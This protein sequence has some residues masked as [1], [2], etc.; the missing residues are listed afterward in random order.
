MNALDFKNKFQQALLMTPD[1][2]PIIS[3]LGKQSRGKSSFLSTIF[4]DPD[5]PNKSKNSQIKGTDVLYS[6]NQDNFILF[7][8]EGLESSESNISRD[9]LNISSTFI[10]SDLILLH[11][12]Q[13]DLENSKFIKNFAYIFYQSYKTCCKYIDK[14]PSIILLIR[15]PRWIS[16]TKKTL[17]SYKKLVADF[18]EAVN[19]HIKKCS[20]EIFKYVNIFYTQYC[21]KDH[22]NEF[23]AD[24]DIEN[25]C[26]FSVIGYYVIYFQFILKYKTSEYFEMK[27]NDGVVT[28]N[29][30]KFPD[31]ENLVR[32]VG[33]NVSEKLKGR[34][35]KIISGRFGCEYSVSS[36][37]R[38]IIGESLYGKQRIKLVECVFWDARYEILLKSENIDQFLRVFEKYCAIS[39][40]VDELYKKVNKK[41]TKVIRVCDLELLRKYHKENI[42]IIH[43]SSKNDIEIMLAAIEYA[44]YLS[45]GCFIQSFA[46]SLFLKDSLSYQ[47]LF[48]I[49]NYPD[50]EDLNSNF[51]QEISLNLSKFECLSYYDANFK[52]ILKGIFPIKFALY[53]C[54]FEIYSKII[55]NS[56]SH[57]FVYQE[58]IREHIGSISACKFIHRIETFLALFKD[59]YSYDKIVLI[60]FLQDLVEMHINELRYRISLFPCLPERSYSFHTIS[61]AGI[62][63]L[64]KKIYGF[65]PKLSIALKKILKVSSWEVS[66]PLSAGLALS[67]TTGV[68]EFLIPAICFII[69]G[70]QNVNET[71][72]ILHKPLIF[73]R[74]KTVS[75]K[76]QC[77]KDQHIFY[78]NLFK[79]Q[80]N[81]YLEKE[82][83][84]FNDKKFK[85]SCKLKPIQSNTYATVGEIK[86]YI[87]CYIDRNN[88]N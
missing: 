78:V 88:F 16:P 58:I 27:D 35:G 64:S 54:I 80:K 51:I 61:N 39:N 65:L 24:F 59:F 60:Q 37:V 49:L 13:D 84:R 57:D 18:Q 53:E 75:I 74:N 17:E 3:S 5:I 71:G 30:S 83:Y 40:S 72:W 32:N 8:I 2:I 36:R 22:K 56:L 29:Q 1:D 34:I 82:N 69:P 62:I 4:Q 41:F 87:V 66:I 47:A 68:N 85:G 21:M 48:A 12:S 7:D 76:Y 6:S 50:Y 52:D 9:I 81:C 26:H 20:D 86:A 43:E 42:D 10:V 55:E 38:Y 46:L 31:L 25:T 45:V 19:N 67:I 44:R 15:D 28:L 11:I 79:N 33:I 70:V 63:I 77:P 73:K 23:L 14:F